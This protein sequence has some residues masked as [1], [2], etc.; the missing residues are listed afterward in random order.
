MARGDLT[1]AQWARLEPLSPQGKKPGRPPTRIRRQ[2][3]DG[4]RFRTRTGVPWRD[5]PE[6]YGPSARSHDLFRRWRRDGAWRRSYGY[7]S[8]L[9]V[10][11]VSCKSGRSQ[12][13]FGGDGAT[14]PT[15]FAPMRK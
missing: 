7:D 11:M 6:R 15:R 8:R 4:I 12:A 10:G 5:V 3:I 13:T 2:L 1:D 9:A 14:V